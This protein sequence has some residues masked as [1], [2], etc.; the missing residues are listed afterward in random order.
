MRDYYQVSIRYDKTLETG[1]VK[2][3]TEQY[4]IDAVSFTEAESRAI[5]EMTPFITDFSV[6]AIKITPYEEILTSCA[7]TDD[8]FYKCKYNIENI[9]EKNG[10]TVFT[11]FCVL[12]QS[13][14]V[15]SAHKT[16]NDYMTGTPVDYTL[17]SIDETPIMDY[18]S[19]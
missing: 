4:L 14:S 10:N 17:I 15:E 2:K 13:S 7:D 8:K 3:V 11:K 9:N 19:F 12:I 6:T 5:K 16:F 18:Y 1:T